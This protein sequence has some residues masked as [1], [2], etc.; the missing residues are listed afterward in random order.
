MK[1]HAVIISTLFC[2][3]SLLTTPGCAQTMP[4]FDSM[5][6]D[7]GAYL[8]MAK[9]EPTGLAEFAQM[10]GDSGR[11]SL[12]FVMTNWHHLDSAKQLFL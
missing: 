10:V 7:H 11:M 4:E 6:L 3:T 1:T 5:N 8:Q 12:L 2:G 9:E